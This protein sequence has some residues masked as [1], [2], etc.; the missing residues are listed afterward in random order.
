[1]ISSDA[2]LPTRTLYG[3][4]PIIRDMRISVEPVLSVFSHGV[5]TVAILDDYLELESDDIRTCTAYFHA[6]IARNTLA[7]ISVSVA[8]P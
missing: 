1:M 5:S 2:L 4:K 7:T 8:E 6:V 3:G